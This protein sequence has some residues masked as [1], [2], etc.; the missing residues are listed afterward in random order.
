[1]EIEPAYEQ[2]TIYIE[3]RFKPGIKPN[4]SVRKHLE[5]GSDPVELF[6]FQ[7]TTVGNKEG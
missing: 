7:V 5:N 3:A 2:G 4:I 1:M 6:M